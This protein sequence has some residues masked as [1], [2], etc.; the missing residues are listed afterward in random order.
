MV[1]ASGDVSAAGL[2]LL[3][4][5]ERDLD[6]GPSIVL[7]LEARGEGLLSRTARVPVGNATVSSKK[8][9]KERMYAHKRRVCVCVCVCKKVERKGNWNCRKK[10]LYYKYLNQ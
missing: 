10:V 4:E 2:L 7:P 8:V 3:G 5:E 9:S 6:L 1:A